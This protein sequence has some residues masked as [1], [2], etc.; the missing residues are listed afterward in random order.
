LAAG[1]RPFGRRRTGA[2]AFLWPCCAAAGK[3]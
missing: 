2:T 1:R 3:P